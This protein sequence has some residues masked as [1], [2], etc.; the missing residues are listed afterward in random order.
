[1]QQQVHKTEGVNHTK[2]MWFSPSFSTGKE[3]DEE[4]G[5][6]YFGARYMDH[7]L[8]TMWLSVDPMADKYPSISPYAYCNWNPIKLID[9]DG[10]EV[11]IPPLKWIKDA[12]NAWKQTCS[13]E[14]RF[15][16]NPKAF[17][18]FSNSEIAKNKAK[19]M[20]P[21]DKGRGTKKD[22]FRHALWQAMNVQSV[23]EDFTRKYSE[24]HEYGTPR[25]DIHTDLFMD[26][27]NN[28]VGIE[29]GRDNP[30]ASVED[31][32][33]IIQDRISNGD[34][35][36]LS[37]PENGHLLKSDGS[38]VKSSEIRGLYTARKIAIEIYNGENE[39][40]VLY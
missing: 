36:I 27:H 39:K 13:N 31:L 28:E 38:P 21:E 1:M 5:Y 24:A 14:K 9:P 40:H 20:F 7:E 18:V 6:G 29:I 15:L 32:C 4:T 17:T 37:G 35:L 22:A 3:R 26:I 10:R 30:N 25:E 34:M 2:I 11:G 12:K 23:G 33:Q 16:L 19:E 8:M